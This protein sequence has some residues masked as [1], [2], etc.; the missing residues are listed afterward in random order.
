[1]YCLPVVSH[2]WWLEESGGGEMSLVGLV[3][4]LFDDSK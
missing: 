1:M 4:S 2:E 3:A